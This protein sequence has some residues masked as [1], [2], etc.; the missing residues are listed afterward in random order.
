[1]SG[2]LDIESLKQPGQLSPLVL[3]YVGDAVYELSVRRHLVIKGLRGVNKLHRVAVK[4][5]CADSQAKVIM[6]LESILTEE[7]AAVARRGRN[8]KSGHSP[9]ATCVTNYRKSTGLESLVGFLFLNGNHTR[10]KEIMDFA[11]EFIEGEGV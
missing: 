1:M 10:L 7:E 11:L 9:K 8:A 6:A 2:Y 3:A 5:V 4:Y